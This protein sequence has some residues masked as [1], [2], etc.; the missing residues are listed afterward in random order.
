MTTTTTTTT[1][2]VYQHS[3]SHLV[4]TPGPWWG[5]YVFG[6]FLF[7]CAVAVVLCLWLL[8]LGGSALRNGMRRGEATAREHRTSA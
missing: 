1:V 7:L 3:S 2:I 6:A 8:W 5:W 4:A